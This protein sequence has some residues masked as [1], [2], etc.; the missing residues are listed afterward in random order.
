MNAPHTLLSA[1]STENYLEKMK[2]LENGK[3]AKVIL[4]WRSGRFA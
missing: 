2:I 4:N 3:N 1:K